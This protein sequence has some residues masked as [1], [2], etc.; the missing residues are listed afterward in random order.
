MKGVKVSAQA[1]MNVM[2]GIGPTGAPVQPPSNELILLFGVRKA[3]LHKNVNDQCFTLIVAG[4]DAAGVI[5]EQVLYDFL[6]PCPPGET[7]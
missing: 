1:L 7:D 6:E 4:V 5:Q 3:D 2:N